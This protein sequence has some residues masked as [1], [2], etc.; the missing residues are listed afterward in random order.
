[1]TIDI[2][3]RNL[4]KGMLVGAAGA[5]SMSVLGGCSPQASS[6]SNEAS[7]TAG[8]TSESVDYASQV[9][10]T[11]DC[12]IV[13]VG[14]G[15]SGLSAAVEALNSGAN[16][17]VLEAQTKAGGNGSTTSVVM[18][19][20][21]DMQKA[22]GIEVTPAQIISTEMETFNYSVDGVRWSNLIQ[23]SVENINWLIEQGALFNGMVDNYHGIGIV[24]TG[25][26]WTGDTGR[27]GETGF[28]TP[29]V[30]RVEE[31]GGT[32][33]YEAAGKQLI[34]GDDGVAGVY[35]EQPNGIL[36][37][38]SKAVILATG[39]YADNTDMLA[40]RG[41]AADN[42]AVFGTPGHNGDGISMALAAG[43]KSWMDESSLMEYPM[44]PKIGRSSSGI[45]SISNTIWVNGNGVRFV[46]EN[47]GAKVPAR[48]A[49]AVRS[50]EISYA[51]LDQAVL[52]A[53]TAEDEEVQTMV[54]E[55]IASGFIFK[56]DTIA[57]VAEAAGIDA[58][59]LEE[60]L[61]T[62]NSYCEAGS[63]DEFGKDASKLQALTTAPY[64]L[65]ENSGIY[66][67]TTIGGIDTTPECE[68]RA[69]EG[70][71]IRGLYAVGVDGV[72][73]YKGLYTIDIPGSCNANNINSGRTAAKQACALL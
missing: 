37:I 8:S 24:D 49:L 67:L 19:V 3:R 50:Q 63:D 41:Y 29:M 62:Y 70:G 42:I 46:D 55:G 57:E 53:V 59:A 28:V 4:L 9:A 72:E 58:A 40:E 26:W 10:N 32:I 51:L 18:G 11:M 66:F 33:L 7:S 36:Q 34:M 43:A 44:N 48:P 68:V 52:D 45:S 71:I 12:D 73:L 54:D 23:N 61:A 27:D 35:V 47:C 13:V 16:V 1:M 5:A 22:L 38:N 56:G 14:A 60:T 25:H 31:L 65:S 30:A 21:S 15:M 69:E 17:V 39:G 6:T 64:Y 20:G 2:S